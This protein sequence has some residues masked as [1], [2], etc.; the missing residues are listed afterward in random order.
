M[1][2]KNFDY[3]HGRFGI[4]PMEL[5]NQMTRH[6]ILNKWK[7]KC[8]YEIYKTIIKTLRQSWLTRCKYLASKYPHIKPP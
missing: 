5:S 8:I 4:L 7:E 3:I 2:Y 1:E 6:G